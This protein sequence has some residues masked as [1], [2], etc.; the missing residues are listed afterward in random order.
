MLRP[1]VSGQTSVM[2][3]TTMCTHSSGEVCWPHCLR[4]VCRFRSHADVSVPRA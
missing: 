2:V 1:A 3:A 4:C